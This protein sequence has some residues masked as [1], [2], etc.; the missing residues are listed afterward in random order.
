MFP[1][2][3]CCNFHPCVLDF[4][5]YLLYKCQLAPV[6]CVLC[7]AACRTHPDFR[8]WFGLGGPRRG[9]DQWKSWNAGLH[10]Y[11]TGLPVL[12]ALP[13]SGRRELTVW[14]VL[15]SSWPLWG[16][17]VVS[18]V[19]TRPH[20]LLSPGAEPGQDNGLLAVLAGSTHPS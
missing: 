3:Y 11:V 8:S 1:S 4:F 2:M 12:P 7:L 14:R 10:G 9:E 15:G 19:C 6:I 20:L 13:A 18:E 17:V 5:H 16:S